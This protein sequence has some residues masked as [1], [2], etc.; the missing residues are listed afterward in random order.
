MAVAQGIGGRGPRILHLVPSDGIG[1]VEVAAKSMRARAD[2]AGR[3]RLQFI[4]PPASSGR[5]LAS[6][7]RVLAANARALRNARAFEPDVI[8]CSLWR[9]VPLALALKAIHRRAR[10]VYFLHHDSSV[11][12]FDAILS[13]IAMRAADQIWG[14]SAAALAA[15]GVRAARGRAISFVTERV[16]RI[17]KRFPGP[18]FVS[19][20]RLHRQKGFDRALRLIRLLVDR[21]IDARYTIYGPDG[22]ARDTLVALARE[23]GIEDRVGF[24]GP[25]SREALG[26]VAAQH[27]FFLQLSRSEG[28]CM[29]AVEAMQFGLV[30]AATA[31]GQM[32]HYV[33]PGDT[34]VLVDPE[35]MEG[36]AAEI[37]A[38]VRDPALWRDRS[39]AAMRY[40]REAPLYADDVCQAAAAL[41]G[42]SAAAPRG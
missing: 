28:M 33:I 12:R 8:L 4:E 11:H 16:E 41:A 25:V 13:G 31:I 18:S 3:F 23:L 34:G 27:G 21:G 32:A 9:S 15:R 14:D 39:Q 24:P 17:D 35:R 1:G 5:S 2:L 38:L 7:G 6:F 10:L 36:A 42:T 22:G 40:W 26:S 19:W 30:P 37:A 20:G 29:A